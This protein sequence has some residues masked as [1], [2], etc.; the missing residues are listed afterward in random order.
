MNL[1]EL[2]SA[3]GSRQNNWRRGRG[4]GGKIIKETLI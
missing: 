1:S 3:E 2:K 4:M